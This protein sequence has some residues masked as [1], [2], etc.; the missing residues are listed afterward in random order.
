[1]SP[2]GQGK[3]FQVA[4][5]LRPDRGSVQ[6]DRGKNDSHGKTSVRKLPQCGRLQGNA[7]EGLEG[8]S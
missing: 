8:M 1:M 7:E 2:T 5:Y 6:P 3:V 4:E